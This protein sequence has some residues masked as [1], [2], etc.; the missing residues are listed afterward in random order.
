MQKPDCYVWDLDGTL[1]DVEHRR[2]FVTTNPKNWDAWN[3]GL[4][5]D[6]ENFPV[7][8][9]YRH[10]SKSGI[11]INVYNREMIIVSGRSEDYKAQTDKWLVDHEIFYDEIYM[12][13]S[14]DSRD[15]AIVKSE[16]A[17]QIEEKYNII[18]VFDDRQK[19]VRMW[20]DRGIFVFDVGQGKSNF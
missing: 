8:D 4:V 1:C 20:Q 10:L 13:K 18:A 12:R 17:D 11:C 3:A 7:A 14:G 16:F 19:V 6:E 2:K 15:D 9:V 5:C